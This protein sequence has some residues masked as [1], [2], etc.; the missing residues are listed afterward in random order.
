MTN[1]MDIPFGVGVI[2]VTDG[3]VL[4]G[5]RTDNGLIC[6]PG[7]HIQNGEQPSESAL[8]ELQEEF[9]IKANKLY[10]LG[11]IQDPEGKWKPSMVFLCTDHEG[12]PKADEEE[13][14][15]A[16]FADIAELSQMDN[17]FPCFA[18][19]LALLMNRLG[20]SNGDTGN[21]N[22]DASSAKTLALPDGK[23]RVKVENKDGGPGSGNWGHQSI[24]GTRG[25]SAPGGGA[26][27]RRTTH[28]AYSSAAKERQE[29]YRRYKALKQSLNSHMTV[30]EMRKTVAEVYE[31]IGNNGGVATPEHVKKA[32][33][34]VHAYVMGQYSDEASAVVK[35]YEKANSKEMSKTVQAIKEYDAEKLKLDKVKRGLCTPEEAGFASEQDYLEADA[36][37]R[38]KSEQAND[39][40]A[41]YYE[42]RSEYVYA[43]ER[44]KDKSGLK[45]EEITTKALGEIRDVGPEDDLGKILSGKKEYVDKAKIVYSHL[46]TSWN[47][48]FEDFGEDPDMYKI[49][50]LGSDGRAFYSSATGQVSFSQTDEFDTYYHEY[51]HKIEDE[52]SGVHEVVMDFYNRRT[53]GEKSTQLVGYDKR[54]VTKK[55]SFVDPYIGKVYN[56]ATEVLS[57]GMQY[58]YTDNFTM[59]RDPDMCQLIYGILAVM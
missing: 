12:E 31:D 57:M 25:G 29:A 17:L 19:S 35:A 51:G 5:T 10:P 58:A 13:M 40:R 21:Q 23:V 7:G 1:S 20:M 52:I 9:N 16:R 55:D 34:A 38:G 36:R 15:E 54:E 43:V 22:N 28:G 42:T 32:G 4:I 14:T 56:G 8:R 26:N 11:A 49:N 46:P 39:L 33:T 2:V 6:G 3:K 59:M 27:Y 18:A 50:D 53:A 30:A 45:S 24:K 48:T 37:L 41:K 44:L 47:P